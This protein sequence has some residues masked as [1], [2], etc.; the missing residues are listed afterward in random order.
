LRAR[1]A[2]SYFLS[3]D[4]TRDLVQTHAGARGNFAPGKQKQVLCGA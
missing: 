4:C 1:G 3:D 2:G